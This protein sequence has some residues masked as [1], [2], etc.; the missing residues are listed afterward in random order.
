MMAK[1]TTRRHRAVISGGLHPHYRE[2]TET[3]ARFIG[4]DLDCAGPDVAGEEDLA[5]RVDERTSC[6]VVQYPDVFGNVRDW[7]KLAEACH[8]TGAQIGR[9][10]GR[11]RV[12]QYV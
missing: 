9:A 10:S 3:L 8:A 12:G 7:T 4:F 5:A 11:G 6:V 2:V 1:R